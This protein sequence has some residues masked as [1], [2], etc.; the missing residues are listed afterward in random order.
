MIPDFSKK[1][2]DTLAKRAAYLCSNPDCR[3]ITVGPNTDPN[4]TIKI[5]E[6][7]HIY[8][9]RKTAKRY[10]EN[11]SDQTRSEITNAIWLC[12]NCHKSI[13]TDSDRYTSKILFKW[14]ELHEEYI[15]SNLGSQ[16]EQITFKE[17]TSLL[18]E[19]ENYPPIIKRI[20]IDKPIDWEFKLTIE[21]M[22]FLNEPLFRKLSDLQNNLYIKELTHIHYNNAFSWVQDRL[23]EMLVL[24]KP[25][26]KLPDALTKSWGPSGQSGDVKE[27]HH[28]TKLFHQYL[29]KVILFEE[30]IHFVNIPSEYTQIVKL[31]QNAIGTQVAQYSTIPSDL[32]DILVMVDEIENEDDLPKI[33]KKEFVFQFPDNFENEFNIELEKL[34]YKL[35]QN[36]FKEDNSTKPNT[37]GCLS[38]IIVLLLINLTSFMF[39]II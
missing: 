32:E 19:F 39:V 33:I 17:Q 3:T 1:T 4:K 16:T 29:Q 37:I 25:A 11:M 20:I 22:R 7:A 28:V 31:L 14:R 15:N 13:D 26:I 30:K 8:G 18:K 35:S 34:Q 10:N 9:A 21:L 24:I 38:T 27:I 23:S 6:A 36:Q 2:I 12:R 5:G